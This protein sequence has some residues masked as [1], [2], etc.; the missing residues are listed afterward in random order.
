MTT[1][2]HL[3]YVRPG[4]QCKLLRPER[5][6]ESGIKHT[7]VF[8]N[9]L[10]CP[11][12]TTE[13]TSRPKFLDCATGKSASASISYTKNKKISPKP[14]GLVRPNRSTRDV[15][16]SIKGV[17]AQRVAVRILVTPLHVYRVGRVTYKNPRTRS[18]G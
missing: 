10:P 3:F 16:M 6:G 12:R 13:G 9:S 7:Y 17:V 14:P 18:R 5:S 15:A 8:L 2:Y 1:G 11:G 4:P